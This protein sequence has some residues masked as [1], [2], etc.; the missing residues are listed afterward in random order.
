MIIRSAQFATSGGKPE[1]YPRDNFP[2]IAFAGRSNVGKSSLINALVRNRGLAH[3]SRT[4]GRTQRINFF[5]INGSLYFVDLPGYGFAKVPEPIR[6]QW[7]PMIESYLSGNPRLR[8]VIVIV[9]ARHAVSPLDLQLIEYV[10]DQG[11]AFRVVATK[12]DKVNRS[13][14]ALKLAV[15]HAALQTAPQTAPDAAR[16]ATPAAI[17]PR[18]S[19]PPPIPFSAQTGEGRGELLNEI[20]RLTAI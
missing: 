4:P 8:G 3:S 15:I 11:I 10:L 9:D 12:I 19:V 14:R 5:A 7:R 17:V 1:E 18:Q 6:L 13:Q 20:N 16:H 2:Q